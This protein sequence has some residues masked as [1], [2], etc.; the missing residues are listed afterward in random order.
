MKDIVTEGSGS[1][2]SSKVHKDWLAVTEQLY[3]SYEEYEYEE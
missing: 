2:A 3:E 1:V